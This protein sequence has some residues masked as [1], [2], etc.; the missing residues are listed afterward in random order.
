M[1]Q[2]PSVDDLSPVVPAGVKKEALLL[3]DTSGSMSYP[4]ADGSDVSRIDVLGEAMGIIVET[5]GAED[6]EAEEEAARGEDAGGLMTV[7]FAHEAKV[8][9]D[10]SPSNWRQKWASI[11]WGGGTRI[12]DGWDLLVENFLK[13]FGDEPPQD[14]PALLALVLTDGEAEDM[15]EFERQCDK[16]KGSTYIAVG[17]LG[18]GADHDATVD[19]YKQIAQRNNH[20]RVVSFDSQTDPSALAKALI[21]LMG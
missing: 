9:G 6:S 14:R 20:V 5:L 18:Y 21:S 3:L 10:L 11:R 4:A 12:M 7:T 13:E 1:Q 8:L 15:E 16:A 17:V 19:A 2:E